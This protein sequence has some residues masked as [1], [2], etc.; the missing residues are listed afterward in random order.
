[1]ALSMDEFITAEIL[2]GSDWN[3]LWVHLLT[4][5]PAQICYC[6]RPALVPLVLVVWLN[7]SKRN[8]KTQELFAKKNI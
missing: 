6:L 1:M 5:V 4:D 3:S 8:R 7:W 2:L